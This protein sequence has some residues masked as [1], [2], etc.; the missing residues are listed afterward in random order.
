MVRRLLLVFAALAGALSIAIASTSSDPAAAAGTVV[1]IASTPTGNGYWVAAS[2]GAVSS[3]GDAGSFG[4]MAGRPLNRPIVGIAATPTGRGY[5]LVA[6]DGGMFS[7][8]DAKFLGSMGGKPLNSPIVSM[9]ATSNGNGYWQFAADGGV[10]AFGD[11]KFYGSMGGK[12]LNKPVVGGSATAAGKGYW[13]VASDGG[14]FAFGDAPFAGSTGSIA[15]NQ[16]IQAISPTADDKGYRL[17]AADG[18]VFSFNAPFFGNALGVSSPVVGLANRPQGDGYWLVT[19]DGLVIARGAAQNFGSTTPAL[20]SVKV[21]NTPFVTAGSATAM[22]TRAGDSALYFAERTGTVK[23]IRNGAIDASPTLTIA[24]VSVGGERGLLGLAF[25]PDGTKLYVN[26]TDG[27]GDLNIVEYTMNATTANPSS[28][29][30]LLTIEHSSQSNHN[31]GDLHV[32]ADG[33]LWIAV[34]D[35]GGGGDPL[36]AGQS[37]N[38]LLGKILRID[39][40]TPA[41]GKP[42]S[43]PS[44]NPFV[45]T[46]GALPEI[47]AY[48]LR[49]PWRF[50]FDRQTGD[51]WIGDVGQ[52]AYEEIN[53]NLAPL[54]G[55]QNYGWNAMEGS[56]PYNG[57][58][59]PPGSTLPLLD[60]GR[61]LGSSVTGGY[62]Y[63]G[64]SIRGLGGAYVFGDYGSGR[65]WAV[66]QAGGNVIEGPVQ[67]GSLTHVSSFAEDQN[68]ELY[69]ISVD[70]PIVKLTA[71]A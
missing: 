22:T 11:A 60:Y 16:P 32:T 20:S 52:G 27:G 1:A 18:G 13:L 36:G 21:V 49:N 59:P 53:L 38:T 15:L 14:V 69:A 23:A 71:G 9:T 19:A 47:W 54:Q 25:S 39:P 68:G 48:G 50:S 42:Y 10:F 17:V 37:R 45:G 28:A 62:V 70:G 29:R 57:G 34:G 33:L 30:T 26:Y 65:I 46:A 24:G 4:S 40:R 5:W 55:G 41:N 66:K 6:T 3:F 7:F 35:G 12:P 44:N 56:H 63:R 43:I 31:G 61:D 8:G 67:I 51:L 58:S 2:D 64:S